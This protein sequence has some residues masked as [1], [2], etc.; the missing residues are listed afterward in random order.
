[1]AGYCTLDDV[2]AYLGTDK[3]ADDAQLSL[4]I[5]RAR[6][7]I[8]SYCQRTFTGVTATRYYHAVYDVYQDQRMLMLDRDLL[9]VTRITNGDG[10]VLSASNYL[11]L[12]FNEPPYYGIMLR[13]SSGKVWTYINDPE[14]AIVVEGTWG[15]SSTPPDDIVH[16][17]VRLVA[18]YYHQ[19]DAPFETQGMPELGVVTVPSDMPADIKAL[20][21]PY[22]RARVG[23]V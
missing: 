1:M 19:A 21:A 17:A 4:L 23:S 2:K 7:R 11:L 3:V 12:P 16:A 22:Q 13:R 5:E 20:L 8:D 14:A 15:F 18:W 10:E 6:A 9:T